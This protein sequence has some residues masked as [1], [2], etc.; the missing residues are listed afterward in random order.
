M[1]NDLG[2]A[3]HPPAQPYGFRKRQFALFIS[4]CEAKPHGQLLSADI[5]E[6]RAVDEG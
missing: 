1:L 5:L 4:E 6:R 3:L 2:Q